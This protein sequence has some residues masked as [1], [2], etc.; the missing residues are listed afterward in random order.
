MPRILLIE[1]DA[2]VRAW[3]CQIL[4]HFGH[5]VIEARDGREGLD[6]LPGAAADLVITDIVM[7]EMEGLGVLMELR[8]KQPPMKILA[9]SGGGSQ[10]AT[11][12]LHTAKLLGATM[13]LAKPFSSAVL[14][15]TINELLPGGDQ[16]AR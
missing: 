5:I 8:K 12:Y 1:D 4:A 9:M 14:M 7:P 3:L 10:S 15:A 11:D 2:A 13:V 16:V 6:L